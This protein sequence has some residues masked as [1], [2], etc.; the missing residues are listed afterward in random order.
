MPWLR[1]ERW[2]ILDCR[3]LCSR[4]PHSG[5][6]AS[7]PA[8]TAMNATASQTRSTGNGKK[9]SIALFPNLLANNVTLPTQFNIPLIWINGYLQ[10]RKGSCDGHFGLRCWPRLPRAGD[11]NRAALPL[12]R[13][14]GARPST[15]EMI[16]AIEPYRADQDDI[17]RDNSGG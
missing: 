14:A 8:I 13:A 5:A 3:T 6:A 16:D 4:R 10:V 2:K 11:G 15:D 17:D 9:P 12:G 1:G 7:M